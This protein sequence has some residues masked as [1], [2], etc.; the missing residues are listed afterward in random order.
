MQES[1]L[2]KFLMD[3]DGHLTRNP[4][5]KNNIYKSAYEIVESIKSLDNEGLEVFIQVGKEQGHINNE[6]EFRKI[7]E[8]IR[9]N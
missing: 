4:D 3:K 8:E 6:V 2:N 1:K 5:Y 9:S 7:I